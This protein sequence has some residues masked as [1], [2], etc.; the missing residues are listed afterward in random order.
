VLSGIPIIGWNA[1]AAFVSALSLPGSEGLCSELNG[2]PLLVIPHYSNDSHGYNK[3]LEA[4]R[5]SNLLEYALCLPPR[6]EASGI[7]IE[8]SRTGLAGGNTDSGGGVTPADLTIYQRAGTD[9]VNQVP[10]NQDQIN[11]LP[12][13]YW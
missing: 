1:G 13:N 9:G 5:K 12:I 10:F 7:V 6:Q 3:V 2:F 11:H 4:F 8:E